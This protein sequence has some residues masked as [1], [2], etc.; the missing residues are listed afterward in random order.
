MRYNE[1]AHQRNSNY[2]WLLVF[3]L[4]LLFFPIFSPF[5]RGYTETIFRISASV[6][7]LWGA[8][9]VTHTKLELLICSVLASLAILGFWCDH[10][11]FSSGK[12]FTIFRTLTGIVYFGYLGQRI[13]VQL[14]ESNREV[15]LNLV[16]GS[17][18]VYLIIGI[19]GGELCALMDVLEPGTF[20]LR[21]DKMSAYNYYYFSFVT[22]TTV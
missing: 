13:A 11:F 14:M 22:L 18:I 21:E 8:Y 19:I 6:I 7:I 4:S 9:A 15:S 20:F 16:Y 12:S 5:F 17:I 2:F 10:Y 1:E 3:F